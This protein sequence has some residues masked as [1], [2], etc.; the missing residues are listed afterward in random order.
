MLLKMHFSR[1]FFCSAAT[2]MLLIAASCSTATIAADSNPPGADKTG[3]C[4]EMVQSLND[5]IDLMF[6]GQ[7]L[8]R[9]GRFTEALQRL[10]QVQSQHPQLAA[11]YELEG[12]IYYVRKKYKEAID[13]YTSAT[14]IHPRNPEATRMRDLLEEQLAKRVPAGKRG[15]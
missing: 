12:G 3:Q 1:I 10:K 2:A 8:A 7:R 5:A 11:P 15:P 4:L 9:A 6:E 13:A 14:R